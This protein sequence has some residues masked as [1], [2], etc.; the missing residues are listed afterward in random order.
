MKR[1]LH[2]PPGALPPL[3]TW[4]PSSEVDE[5]TIVLD[6]DDSREVAAVLL[7]IGDKGDWQ[8]LKKGLSGMNFVWPQAVKFPVKGRF[9]VFVWQNALSNSFGHRYLFSVDAD[10]RQVPIKIVTRTRKDWEAAPKL[11]CPIK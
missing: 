3:L 6:P 5:V 8:P 10:H 7:A 9:Y 1:P 4:L 11:F 2:S